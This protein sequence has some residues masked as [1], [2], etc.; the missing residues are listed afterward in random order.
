MAGDVFHITALGEQIINFAKICIIN[1]LSNSALG[2]PRYFCN[3]FLG[4]S[5]AVEPDNNAVSICFLPG[6][7][8][9]D[10]DIDCLP[11]LGYW[12]RTKTTD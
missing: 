8:I 6:T 11:G 10:P 2:R 7:D 4:P 9:S 1:N 5:K 12:G 3:L